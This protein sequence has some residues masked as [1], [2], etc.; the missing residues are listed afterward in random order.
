LCRRESVS[1]LVPTIDTELAIYSGSRQQFE[2]IGTFIFISSPETVAIARDKVATHQWLTEH[3]FPT[4]RQGSPV[5]V[6]DTRFSWKLPLIAKPR[7]GS[8]SIG[9]QVIMAWEELDLL[10]QREGQ[11]YIVQEFAPG[12][13]YTVNVYVDSQGQCICT[14]PHRRI[15][16][17]GGEVSKAITVKDWRLMSVAQSIAEELPE[18]RGPM[19]IQCF[20][21]D[22][23]EVNIIEINPRFGGGYPLAHKAGARFT[24][25]M[26][27]ELEGHRVKRCDD[28]QDGLVMLRYD[29]AVYAPSSSLRTEACI[30]FA[31]FSISTTPSF[32]KETT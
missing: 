4:V 27:D 23:G 25:W 10:A 30:D 18:A 20:M 31:S 12:N 13:E 29:E 1:L 14:V 16:V 9:V 19:N 26:I 3:G 2:A 5:E 15:E 28:W 6:L 8:A 21:T 11:G 7:D 17:R 32:S 22:S 24:H